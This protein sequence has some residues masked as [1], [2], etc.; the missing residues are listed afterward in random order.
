[1]DDDVVGAATGVMVLDEGR[2]PQYWVEQLAARGIPV[3]ERT[4]REWA[5][6]LGACYR[7]GRAMII[8]TAQMNAIL[9]S[10]EGRPSADSGE[11]RSSR[12]TSSVQSSDVVDRVRE[13]LVRQAYGDSA[14]S[15]KQR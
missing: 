4:I 8:T 15:K 2:P 14:K 6:N 9:R 12:G 13:R 7:V 1:V 3:S 5:N 11:R 10:R